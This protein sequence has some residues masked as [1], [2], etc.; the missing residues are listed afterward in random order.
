MSLVPVDGFGSV[1]GSDQ[2]V[3][4]IHGQVMEQ[5][6][7]DQE[8]RTSP[9]RSKRPAAPGSRALALSFERLMMW[10][11]VQISQWFRF[12]SVDGA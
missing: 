2:S 5:A 11:M 4:Q 9:H 8:K 6:R 12:M 3:I 1:N 7:A 10:T